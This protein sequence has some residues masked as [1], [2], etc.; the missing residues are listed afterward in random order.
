MNSFPL[1]AFWLGAAFL[2]AIALLFLLPPLL[3]R[4]RKTSAADSVELNAAVYRARLEELEREVADGTLDPGDFEQAKTEL[5]REILENVDPDR[6]ADT[7]GGHS[8]A[9]AVCVVVLLP[10]LAVSLY[11]VLGNPDAVG[12]KRPEQSAPGGGESSATELEREALERMAASFAERLAENPEEGEGWLILGR[13]YVMLERYD[14][15][16]SAFSKA[17]AVLGDTPD[18]LADYAEAEAMAN[19]NRFPP[20]ARA[21]IDTALSI[22][23]RHEKALW[24]GAFA[25]AQH[26]DIGVAIAHWQTLLRTETDPDRRRLIEGLIARVGGAPS[27]AD[28]PSTAGAPGVT[29]RVTL[30]E[31]LA[32]ELT[33]SETVFVFARD[34][35]GQGP[36]LAVFRT[37][38]DSIPDTITLDDSMAMVPALKLSDRREVAVVAR[39][40][41]SGDAMPRSG[42]IQGGS[43]PVAVGN[44]TPV[45][46]VIN[47]RVP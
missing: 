7:N 46:I 43:A 34:P 36:P 3:A 26:G 40:S 22:A 41:L 9:V 27:A 16:V 30:D 12:F 39:V 24:L 14:Q 32:K 5:E 38:V 8:K 1:C 11:L 31:G 10:V 44:D 2:T 15:A 21:R 6:P 33:G 29:V 18:L 19:N 13:A 47:E 42:D 25:A 4:R 35:S 28:T 37:R 45:E 23:P 20:A 17:N